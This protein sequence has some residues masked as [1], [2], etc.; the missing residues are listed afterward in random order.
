MRRLC[1][2]CELPLYKEHMKRLYLLNI[3][4]HARPIY[5]LEEMLFRYVQNF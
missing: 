5:S 3:H 1:K 2:E 4:S